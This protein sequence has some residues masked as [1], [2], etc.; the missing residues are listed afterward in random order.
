MQNQTSVPL[1]VLKHVC[2]L[3]LSSGAIRR[4]LLQGQWLGA[5]PMQVG[6]CMGCQLCSQALFKWGILQIQENAIICLDGSLLKRLKPLTLGYF[7]SGGRGGRFEEWSLDG[8]LSNIG[9]RSFNPTLLHR[10]SCTLFW[11]LLWDVWM[12]SSL[13][14]WLKGRV[15]FR[16]QWVSSFWLQASI[17]GTALRKRQATQARVISVSVGKLYTDFLKRW[18]SFCTSSILHCCKSSVFQFILHSRCIQGLCKELLFGLRHFLLFLSNA[19]SSL[20][21]QALNFYMYI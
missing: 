14:R 15:E 11:A 13:G 12:F 16:R 21:M 3:V 7:G 18:S 6:R 10:F 4:A 19:C 9:V 20:R 17:L 2:C 5:I 1:A 8:S